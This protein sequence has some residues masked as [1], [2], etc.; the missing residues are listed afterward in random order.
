LSTNPVDVALR[1]SIDSSAMNPDGSSFSPRTLFRTTVFS[2]VAITVL[3]VSRC[4][5][6][7][8]KF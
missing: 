5:D 8:V 2:V 6:E 7:V 1:R 4:P 3:L